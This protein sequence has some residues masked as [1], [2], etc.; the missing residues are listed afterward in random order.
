MRKHITPP[1]IL[2][3]EVTR[4]C[5]N[6]CIMC[7]KGQHDDYDRRDISDVALRQVKP[8]FPYLRHAMLF[9]DGE[10]ML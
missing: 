8:I 9:G 2:Q 3:L 4:N 7:H 1:V 6:A 10:P 5:N